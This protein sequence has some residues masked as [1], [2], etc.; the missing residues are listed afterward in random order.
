MKRLFTLSVLIALASGCGPLDPEL[1]SATA[2]EPPADTCAI[3]DS[4]PNASIDF[5]MLRDVVFVAECSCHVETGGIG[6][7]EG[8]LDLADYDALMA[9]GRNSPETAVIAGDPCASLLVQKLGNAPPF[10][11]RMPFRGFQLADPAQ[12]MITDWIAEGAPR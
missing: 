7:T 8:G 10:G 9:G 4:D 11:A 6:R 1:G 2:I 3:V 12:Q 5:E